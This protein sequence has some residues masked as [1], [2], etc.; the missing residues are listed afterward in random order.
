MLSVFITEVYI[1]PTIYRQL[2]DY[3]LETAMAVTDITSW[4]RLYLS[5][6][7]DKFCKVLQEIKKRVNTIFKEV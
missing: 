6:E 2:T 3:K 5:I 4:M 1:S 7:T